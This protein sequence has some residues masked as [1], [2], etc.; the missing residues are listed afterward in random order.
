MALAV[1]PV[2]DFPLNDDW[3]YGSAVRSLVDEGTFRLPGWVSMPLIVQILW[4]SLFCLPFG[5]SFT[6][7]RFSTLTMGLVGVLAVYALLREAKAGRKA[8]LLGALL[9]ACNPLYFELSNTFMTDVPFLALATLSLVF[10]MRAI[11]HENHIHILFGSLL[12]CGATLIRQLGIIIPVSFAI[13]YLIRNKP[14]RKTLIVAVLPALLTGSALGTYQI[15]L[16]S[17][18]GLP[19]LYHSRSA[20]LVDRISAGFFQVISFFGLQLGESLAY[21]GLFLF[22]LLILRGRDLW[23]SAPPRKRLRVLIASFSVVIA[24][25][26]LLTWQ[27]H[28]M[29]F[30]GNIWFDMGLGPVRLCDITTLKLPHLPTGPKVLLFCITLVSVTGAA[31]LVLLFLGFSLSFAGK[32][33]GKESVPERRV[34]GFLICSCVLYLIPICLAGL[35]D[36]YLLFLMP[37]LMAITA[38]PTGRTGLPNGRLPCILSSVLLLAYF[39][40]TLGATHDYLAWN[41]AR[42][43]ALHYLTNEAGISHERIDGGFEFNGLYGYDPHYRTVPGADG[44]SKSWWWVRDDEY[45]IALGPVAGYEEVKRYTYTRWI[46]YRGGNVFILHRR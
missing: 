6:A 28:L 12:C 20:D 37:P 30:G 44:H 3:S 41:K 31:I 25:M 13:A 40:F 33:P 45:M 22:P 23:H 21:L 36:R 16:Q 15:L 11:P 18:V 17:T 34:A 8:S 9:L 43:Q 26:S 42:W 27:D 5:F 19:A 29:P 1:N 35:F 38:G 14:N 2:G 4:G 39:T 32:G 7:L 24:I 10:F 46:P